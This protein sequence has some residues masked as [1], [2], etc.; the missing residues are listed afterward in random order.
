MGNHVVR[1][2]LES[3]GN[4]WV[5]FCCFLPYFFLQ[6]GAGVSQHSFINQQC[7]HCPAVLLQLNSPMPALPSPRGASRAPR[8]G[9]RWS[10]R[11]EGR[12]YLP[13]RR[14]PGDHTGGAWRLSQPPFACTGPALHQEFL[15]VTRLWWYPGRHG[16]AGI[17]LSLF[18]SAS[19][20]SFPEGRGVS[21]RN[22]GTW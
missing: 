9:V 4:L 6:S 3:E 12:Q 21:K 13:A 5:F 1:H 11:R 20:S 15:L 2:R 19:G 22:Q 10:A 17:F 8:E 18:Q 14:Q 16:Y 7:L